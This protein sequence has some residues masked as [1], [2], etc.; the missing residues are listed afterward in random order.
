MYA[1]DAR[2]DPELGRR[3]HKCDRERLQDH[4]RRLRV[5]V[6]QR[7]RRARNPE[8]YWA[9]TMVGNALR[10][11]RLVRLPC[12]V[13]GDTKTEAHHDDYSKPLDV[14]W[15]CFEHHRGVKHG[16]M[17]EASLIGLRGY[18]AAMFS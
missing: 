16:H 11:G 18:V 8:K 4:E 15:L 6:Y 13:C 2:R 5:V 9:N 12:E 14:R 3:I 17:T 7:A 1:R 10:D